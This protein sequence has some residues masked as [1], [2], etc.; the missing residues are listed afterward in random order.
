MPTNAKQFNDVVLSTG[1]SI[2]VE[3]M[4]PFH[5]KVVIL[6]FTSLIFNTAVD[7]GGTR[8]GWQLGIN[9]LPR[10]KVENDDPQGSKTLLT[11]LALLA[12][13]PPFATV[14]MVNNQPA[15]PI[16]D[17]GKFVPP[18]PGPSKDPRPGREGQILVKGGFSVQTPKGIIPVAVQEVLAGNFE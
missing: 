3:L 8:G 1:K 9:V 6:A 16:L 13:L 11:G 7:E 12:G 2:P 17:E 5:K 4:V 10:S 18:D 14:F 15:A